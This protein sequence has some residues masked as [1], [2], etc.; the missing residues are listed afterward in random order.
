MQVRTRQLSGRA[1]RWLDECRE[2]LESS[3][4]CPPSISEM[5]RCLGIDRA[6]LTKQFA[7]HFGMPPGAYSRRRRIERAQD[8]LRT[9][10]KP[11]CDVAVETGF[12]DQSHFSRVFAAQTGCTPL[13]FRRISRPQASHYTTPVQD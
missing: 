7:A 8:L 2:I 10:S 6:H 3:L 4:Q 9:T 1:P 11:L 12:Y 13:E 5:S